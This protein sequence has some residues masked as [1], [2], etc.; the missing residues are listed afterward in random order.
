MRKSDLKQRV[1]KATQVDN[2]VAGIVVDAVLDELKKAF[3]A[4]EDVE[5]R[6]F[7]SFRIKHFAAKKAQNI[8]KKEAVIVPAHKKIKFNLSKDIFN[9]INK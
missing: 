7:G 6:H 8:S 9:E 3:I 1:A 4:G 5:F 2:Y